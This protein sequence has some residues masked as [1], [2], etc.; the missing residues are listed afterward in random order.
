MIDGRSCW[1]EQ[2]DLSFLKLLMCINMIDDHL[3]RSSN[4]VWNNYSTGNNKQ[5]TRQIET[6]F[7]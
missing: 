1:S 3:I 5:K 7:A 2:E 6:T 4:G